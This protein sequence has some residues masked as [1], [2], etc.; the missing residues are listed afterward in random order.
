MR[1]PRLLKTYLTTHG[2]SYARFA[3]QV[4]CDRTS[5]AHRCAGRYTPGL[6]LAVRIQ[7]ATGEAVRAEDW[8]P[9]EEHAAA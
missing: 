9:V 2:L 8:I 6:A 3:K 4:S 5:L 1:G 7:R